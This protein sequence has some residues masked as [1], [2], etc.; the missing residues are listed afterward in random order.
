MQSIRSVLVPTLLGAM[1][2]GGLS[3]CAS[4]PERGGMLHSK[5]DPLEAWNRN[6]FTFNEGL[7]KVALKPAAK[8][9]VHTVPPLVRQ[10][11]SNFFGNFADVWSSVNNFLQVKPARGFS[12]LM[13]V[14]T[15]TVFGLGGIFD[16]ATQAGIERTREDFGQ[17]LG[18]WGLPAGPYIVWPILGPSSL[19][20][21]FGLPLD[22]A[23]GAPAAFKDDGLRLGA[24]LLQ[25]VNVRAN[26]LSAGQLLDD[27]ALDRYAFVRDA[28]LQRRYSLLYDGDP[29]DQPSEEDLEES[30][31]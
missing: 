20:D 31:Q 14:G 18:V 28:Y 24:S 12:D 21:S 17:T 27:V 15:N 13:R 3:G 4:A 11:V 22:M 9:Y 7:D 6:V 25:V 5:A 19:R 30:P 16:V 29:P 2:W 26:L 23:A 10:G 8:A 1:L